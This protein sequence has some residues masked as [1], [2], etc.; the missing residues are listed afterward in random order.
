MLV[1]ALAELTWANLGSIASPLEAASLSGRSIRPAEYDAL[2][3]R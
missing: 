2:A 1:R 3:V